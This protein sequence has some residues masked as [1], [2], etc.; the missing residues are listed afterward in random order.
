[1]G[2]DIKEITDELEKGN[3]IGIKY[4]KYKIENFQSQVC[5]CAASTNLT[6]AKGRAEMGL[7]MQIVFQI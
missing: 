6:C 2:A 7:K 3:L 1:M 4:M 5:V